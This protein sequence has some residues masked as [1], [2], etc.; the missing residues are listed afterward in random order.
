MGYGYGW[1]DS[2]RMALACDQCG[3]VG[4]VRKRPCRFKVSHDGYSLPYCPAPALCN[5]CFKGLGGSKG[6]HGERCR[7]G[8]EVSQRAEDERQAGLAAGRL[9][10]RGAWGS[11][12]E[13]VPEGW[14]G[15]AFHGQ[16]DVVEYRLVADEEYGVGGDGGCWMDGYET[17]R[18]W[19]GP[20]AVVL[21]G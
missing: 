17:A 2:G 15:V 12:H 6:V 19:V 16:G 5:P 7:E 13:N 10:R 21:P 14:V 1:S 9:L 20:D 11:W 4:G 18:E 3:A 8:A